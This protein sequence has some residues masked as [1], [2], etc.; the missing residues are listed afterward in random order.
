MI[1]SIR[2]LFMFMIG[3]EC[4]RA[5]TKNFRAIEN[6]VCSSCLDTRTGW[7]KECLSGN[8]LK[9]DGTNSISWNVCFN[10]LTTDDKFKRQ[11]RQSTCS[12]SNAYRSW[13]WEKKVEFTLILSKRRKDKFIVFTVKIFDNSMYWILH[14]SIWFVFTT[15][16]SRY[17]KL[18]NVTYDCHI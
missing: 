13:K 7:S 16:Q 9:I 18:A 12:T 15:L 14:Y 1:R 6:F 17:Q 2:I 8:N 10:S 4:D 5:F 3:F 11:K